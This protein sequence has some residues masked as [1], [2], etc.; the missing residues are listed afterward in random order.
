MLKSHI[1]AK[2]IAQSQLRHESNDSKSLLGVDIVQLV[3]EAY[4]LDVN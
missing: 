4:L 2:C 1:F 3:M